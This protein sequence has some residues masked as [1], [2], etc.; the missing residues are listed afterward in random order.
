MVTERRHQA[1]EPT[2]WSSSIAAAGREAPRILG[3]M[4]RNVVVDDPCQLDSALNTVGV[5]KTPRG[6][7]G[8]A[9]LEGWSHAWH[10]PTRAR[11]RVA[12]RESRFE[13]RV[14]VRS[15]RV[16]NQLLTTGRT[17]CVHRPRLSPSDA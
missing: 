8:E 16:Q 1:I 14:L 2:P 7:R 6:Q 13:H 9:M 15:L 17:L 4:R 5:S 11:P 12:R 3:D 10:S